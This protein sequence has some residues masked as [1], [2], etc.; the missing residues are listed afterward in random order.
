MQ[1]FDDAIAALKPI[2]GGYTNDPADSGGPTNFGITEATARAFGYEGDMKDMPRE[3]AIYIY[4]KRYWDALSLD[5]IALLAAP[6]ALELF[7][8]AVNCGVQQAG[9]WFQRCLNVFNAGGMKYPDMTV[10]G[11]V[12]PMTVAAFRAFFIDR[13]QQGIAMLLRAL[14]SLQGAFYIGLAESQPKDERFV[15]GWI[16]NRVT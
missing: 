8:S 12:G 15:Y 6:V 2:E 9:T 5:P 4:R 13:G 3:V 7:D 11:R 1:A 14:N 16:A 10:D